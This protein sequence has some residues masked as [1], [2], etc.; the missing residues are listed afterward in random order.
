M[1]WMLSVAFPFLKCLVASS[2]SFIIYL[3]GVSLTFSMVAWEFT[4]YEQ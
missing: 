3:G 1:G 2:V 4:D